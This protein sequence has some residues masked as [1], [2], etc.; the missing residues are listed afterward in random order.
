MTR[1]ICERCLE[2][3]HGVSEGIRTPD[4]QDHNKVARAAKDAVTLI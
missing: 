3:S 1:D 2:T 4:I